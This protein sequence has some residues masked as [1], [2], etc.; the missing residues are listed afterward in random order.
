MFAI[1]G[2][3]GQTGTAVANAL[4]AAGV[5]IRLIVRSD[6]P[7][8]ASWRARGAEIAVADLTDTV[9]LAHAFEGVTGTYL[10]NP[11]NYMAGDMFVEARMV[12]S[13][14]IAAANY[15]SVPHVV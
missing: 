14:L 4:L 11:P 8:A 5:P 3:L 15:A 13:S 6:D 12:H 2:A 7:R 1:T 9:R 10:M